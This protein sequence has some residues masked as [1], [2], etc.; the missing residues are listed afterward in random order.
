MLSLKAFVDR[1]SDEGLVVRKSVL[2]PYLEPTGELMRSDSLGTTLMF[3]VE[4]SDL[5]CVGNVVNS[6]DKLYKAL[7]VS[8]DDEAYR[9][10]LNVLNAQSSTIRF[11]ECFSDCF[12]EVEV[13]LS[14]LPFIKFFERDGGRYV[15][16]SVVIARTPDLDSFN[17]SVHRLMLVDDSRVAIRI[18]PRHLY[19]IVNLNSASGVDTPVAI[20]VG[21][22][23]AVLLSA[24]ISP[25]YGVFELGLSDLLVGES[26]RFC[27]TPLYDLPVPCS[28]SVVMEGRITREEVDEGPFL[29]LLELYDRVR[30]QPVI[31]IDRVYLNRVE[32]DR[33]FHVILP[34]GMEHKLLM[35]FPKEAA[36][37]DGVRRVVP[38]VHKVRLTP[39]GGCWL[40]AVISIDKNSEGDSKNAILAAFASHPSLKHVVVVDSDIDPDNISDVEWAI[41]TRVQAGD[42]LIIVRGA[43]GSTLDPSSSDGITDKLGVD[44]T[45]PIKMFDTFRRPKI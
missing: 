35:G 37:W 8:S 5:P 9:K 43:R 3:R 15:T 24:S 23:P 28:S 42:D 22:H 30:K 17:A 13:N 31:C 12:E 6:R 18:V 20:V 16:S 21:V 27:R 1:L 19:R 32:G 14:K 33:L 44:A 11:D 45:A 4:G 38:K 41:A 39:S 2:R 10:L 25:P 29:D 40:H 36:I 34:G 7:K 26:L